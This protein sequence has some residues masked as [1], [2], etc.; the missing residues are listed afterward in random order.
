MS[1]L[2]INMFSTTK[3]MQAVIATVV[4]TLVYATFAAGSK[5]SK[6]IAILLIGLF[7]LVLIFATGAYIGTYDSGEMSIPGWAFG[8]GINA[9]GFVLGSLVVWFWPA[10][11]PGTPQLV[12]PMFL[13]LA[14]TIT[15]ILFAVSLN[16]AA[17]HLASQ[18][19]AGML[20]I[21]FHIAANVSFIVS[22]FACRKVRVWS[23]YLM[24]AA[25]VVY[26][27]GAVVYIYLARESVNIWT[28]LKY[29]YLTMIPA[30]ILAVVIVKWQILLRRYRQS[31]QQPESQVTA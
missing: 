7:S 30:T 1:D 13:S 18:N 3:L 8:L 25:F 12:A 27:A 2:A 14:G 4:F 26:V 17:F 10:R 11:E 22:A 31:A 24:A 6:K 29:V 20:F 9:L 19:A 15:V 5:Y 21:L 16:Y 23:V 28:V